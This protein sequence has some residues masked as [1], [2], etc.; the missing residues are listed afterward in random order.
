M[1]GRGARAAL[2]L[3]AQAVQL[4]TAFLGCA[5]NTA[6]NSLYRAT[7]LN[8]ADVATTVARVYTGRP[9]RMVRNRYV[10]EMSAHAASLPGFPIMAALTMPMVQAAIAQ[11]RGDL[12]PMLAGQGIALTTGASAGT[13][14]RRVVEA[15]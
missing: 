2:A 5:E 14:V 15:L 10:N 9:A 11:G 12:V 3:G 8:A 1:D 7:V 6:V 13:I 4:G